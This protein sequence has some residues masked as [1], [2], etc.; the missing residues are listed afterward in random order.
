VTP[1]IR[2]DRLERL[3][4]LVLV[5]LRT[6]R[7]ISLQEIGATVAG[8]PDD[9]LALRQ[10]FERDKRVLRDNGIPLTLERAENA[11]HQVGY[12]I[13]PEHYYLPDLELTS[14]EQLALGFALAAVRLEGGGG[15]DAIAKL[16]SPEVPELP[17]VA[18]LPSLPALGPLQEAIRRRSVVEFRYRGKKRSVEPYGLCFRSGSWYIVGNERAGAGEGGG[19]LRTYRVDRIVDGEVSAG[20]PDAFAPRDDLDLRELVR[21]VPWKAHGGEATEVVVD[22]DARE[23]RGAVDLVGASA[24]ESR[25]AGGSVRLRFAVGDEE[26]FVAWLVGLG[27]TAVVVSP[28]ALR[29]RVISRLEELVAGVAGRD[30]RGDRRR[31]G[32]RGGAPG[33]G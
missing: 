4:N 24:V 8:Y 5:L 9:P 6:N 17:P 1:R 3:T 11:D 13:L 20:P 23:A 31:S 21:Y 27:D 33:P 15:R 10:A 25:S 19:E 30:G 18:V 14:E 22:V 12:T 7:P 28:R 2:P 32:A 16:G 29:D 26:A